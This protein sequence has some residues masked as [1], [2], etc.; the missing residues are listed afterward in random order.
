MARKHLVFLHGFLES[1]AM[2]QPIVD[3]LSVK[4]YH[5]HFPVLPG[6]EAS[7]PLPAVCDVDHYVK[8]I[9]EQL[10]MDGDDQFFIVAHSFGGYLASHLVQ[11]IHDRVNALCLFQSK[12]GE[13]SAE[14]KNDRR[15]AIVAARENKSLYCRTMIRSC[16]GEKNAERLHNE[17]EAQIAFAT[18]L[19][20]EAIVAAQEV[21]IH[22]GDALEFMRHRRFPL[23][24]FL[25]EDDKSIPLEVALNEI[26]QLPGSMYHLA[27]GIGH[28]GHYECTQ[29]A[30]EF[31]QRIVRA[32]G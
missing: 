13:D 2:W 31:I 23:Y 10:P 24:Y 21:M 29:E 22:R 1:P 19:D 20:T 12:C 26:H 32:N 8:A 15:R 16:Y 27:K 4:S 14:K 6:H 11:S 30:A 17:I 18:S 7:H 3:K 9:V 5:L 25:G 28:M